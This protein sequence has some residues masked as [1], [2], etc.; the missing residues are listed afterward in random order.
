MPRFAVD[1]QPNFVKTYGID[2]RLGVVCST[3]DTARVW[4]I[5]ELLGTPAAIQPVTS[6]LA[7]RFLGRS[8]PNPFATST[9]IRYSIPGGSGAAGVFLGVYDV[10][11]R[12][13][14]RLVERP[15]GAGSYEVAWNGTDA[16]GLEMPRGVYFYRLRVGRES[17]TRRV[18]VVR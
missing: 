7:G 18:V 1:A 4:L 6:R 10:Q 3:A 15:H 9:T 12:L 17:E 13:V 5:E 8:A 16:A 14:R 11:G 2:D